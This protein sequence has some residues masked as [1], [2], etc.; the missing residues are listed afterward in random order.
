MKYKGFTLEYNNDLE[1]MLIYHG[2]ELAGSGIDE[3]D[4][5]KYV[6][7]MVYQ[8]IKHESQIDWSKA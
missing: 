4:A 7:I 2:N 5:K 3:K 8:N 1:E 6:D